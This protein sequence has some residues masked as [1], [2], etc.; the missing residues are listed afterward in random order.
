MGNYPMNFFEIRNTS[1][2]CFL[3]LKNAQICSQNH[4]TNKILF[5]EYK[6]FKFNHSLDK[7]VIQ[8][9]FNLKQF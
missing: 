9:H 3:W 2:V 7:N 1:W 5:D 4:K 6:F 8:H